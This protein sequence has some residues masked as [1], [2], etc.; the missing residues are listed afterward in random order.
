MAALGR[1]LLEYV[2][3]LSARP[4]E[5][6]KKEPGGG[7]AARWS[8]GPQ[9][10]KVQVQKTIDATGPG[11]GIGRRVCRVAGASAFSASK[12]YKLCSL[13][14][15]T[16]DIDH[17]APEELEELAKVVLSAN[18]PLNL[19]PFILGA[20]FDALLCGVF[21]MQCGAYIG[22]KNKDGLI[23][24]AL[25]AFVVAMNLWGTTLSW[26][27]IWDLFVYNF[28][29]YVM[30]SNRALAAGMLV[31]SIAACAG[32][33]GSKIIFMHYDSVAYANKIKITGYICISCTLVLD[34]LITGIILQYL[35][36]KRTVNK[37]TNHLMSR[38]AKVTF[39]SQLPPTLVA[40]ALFCV[41]TAKNDSFFN[42][43]LIL[44]QFKI[45]GISLLH[46]LNV[47][48]SLNES[49]Q[50]SS[51]TPEGCAITSGAL[52]QFDLESFTF[53]KPGLTTVI[54]SLPGHARNG[55]SFSQLEPGHEHRTKGWQ[56]DT[57]DEGSR[58]ILTD[59]RAD[60]HEIRSKNALTQ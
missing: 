21:L 5:K 8:D 13:I 41:Y 15:F 38:L 42:V 22:S 28:G 30:N 39:E 1:W 50:R 47:R 10:W 12:S 2:L 25:V 58:S 34:L 18:K 31:L 26:V 54:D 59:D 37:R 32:G 33:I 4:P 29:T 56:P 36:R 43:P 53:A 48:E 19:G 46:T 23:T 7:F 52:Q 24:K 11:S 40:V 44:M 17:S 14:P 16:M 49:D 27:W 45:Y 35:M 9:R 55:K 51:I 3:D 20:L 6:R 57:D 60:D